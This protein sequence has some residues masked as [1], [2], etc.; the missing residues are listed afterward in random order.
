MLTVWIRKEL[1]YYFSTDYRPR[2]VGFK[3]TYDVHVEYTAGYNPVNN[4]AKTLAIDLILGAILNNNTF[5]SGV[6]SQVTEGVQG[7]SIDTNKNAVF[8]LDNRLSKL[9]NIRLKQI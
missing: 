9:R 8:D 4:R 7:L 6:I 5:Y 2:Q 1:L 3:V